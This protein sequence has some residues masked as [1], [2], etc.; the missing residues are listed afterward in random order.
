[1]HG[2]TKIVTGRS[3]YERGKEH[4]ADFHNLSEKSH[5][6]KHY[7]M[8]H[9]NEIKMQDLKFGMRVRETFNTAI[10]R[11]VGEAV[12]I[13]VE[14]KKGRKLMNSKGEYNRCIVPRITTKSKED[15]YDEKL[16][17]DAKEKIF[18]DK[19]NEL[20]KEKRIRKLE[21]QKEEEENQ[22][23]LKKLKK[24]C[25]QIGNENRDIWKER[26]KNE[27]EKKKELEKEEERE[28]KKNERRRKA[29]EK[30][31]EFIEKVER[32][33]EKLVEKSESWVAERK[34]NWRSY[35]ERNESGS[36]EDS[37][38]EKEDRE[39][40]EFGSQFTYYFDFSKNIL[41]T[42]LG[43]QSSTENFEDNARK[44][45]DPSYIEPENSHSDLIEITRTKCSSSV[46]N[47]VREYP[48]TTDSANEVDNK[49]NVNIEKEIVTSDVTKLNKALDPESYEGLVKSEESNEDLKLVK[50][51]HLS[52]DKVISVE[53]RRELTLPI[54]NSITSEKV[55]ILDEKSDE[56]CTTPNK[57]SLNSPKSQKRKRKSGKYSSKKETPEIMKIL[58]RMK[59]K[60]KEKDEKMSKVVENEKDKVKIDEIKC[61]NKL[62]V[63]ENKVEEEN[64]EKENVKVDNLK[65]LFENENSDENEKSNR[66]DDVFLGCRP[67]I[68]P[69][70]NPPQVA[71]L[72][73]DRSSSVD[74]SP[75]LNIENAFDIMRKNS[76]MLAN[77][78]IKTMKSE[79]KLKK[80]YPKKKL[81][82]NLA[83][84]TTYFETAPSIDHNF[85]GKNR[86]KVNIDF[87]GKEVSE[88]PGLLK[89]SEIDDQILPLE[90]NLIKNGPN[91][92][93]LDQFPKSN[94]PRVQTPLFSENSSVESSQNVR[95]VLPLV[96]LPNPSLTTP[97]GVAEVT[98][99][100]S[101]LSSNGRNDEKFKC[102]SPVL[103]SLREKS[104]RFCKEYPG[105]SNLDSK[106]NENMKR[107]RVGS[108]D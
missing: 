29:A 101:N 37:S 87:K 92:T 69:K 60:K 71:P 10:E 50:S 96:R 54:D 14:Q 79:K 45:P 33:E 49:E 86:P 41:S 56:K 48:N 5:L 42:Q 26:K 6:L 31:K 93:I 74:S 43:P 32:K 35:R 17:E 15:I 12:A 57:L 47:L 39:M 106:K 90:K 72:N 94:D 89:I 21:K 97:R 91:L 76:E 62:S 80:K 102:Q 52:V 27:K 34:K 22:P 82:E 40:I 18:K 104:S 23:T 95:S 100:F 63:I 3:A 13:S 38:I 51:R 99:F 9:Q 67:K 4:V 2:L 1:M 19:I 28:I 70:L 98:K 66:I 36:E 53:N 16:E 11:Q 78:E 61:E 30:K 103:Q 7:I 108:D 44:K 65:I 83:K 68:R 88:K 107:K 24:I 46:R 105:K 8:E 20:K 59:N 81:G 58:E 64:I 55:Y 85:T 25:I 73:V 84:I 75:K 77:S